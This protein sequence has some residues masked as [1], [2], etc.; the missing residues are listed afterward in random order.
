[1]IDASRVVRRPDPDAGADRHFESL[2][3]YPA[4]PVTTGEETAATDGAPA[5]LFDENGRVS[6]AGLGTAGARATARLFLRARR[7]IASFSAAP[8]SVL[9]G[10]LALLAGFLA[11]TAVMLPIF[12]FQRLRRPARAKRRAPIRHIGESR[13]RPRPL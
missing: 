5:R 12:L 2:L 7:A 4:R 6:T 1:M 10:A 9:G 3:V 8:G 11:A 13:R